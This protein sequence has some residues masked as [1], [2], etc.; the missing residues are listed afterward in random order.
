[1]ARRILIASGKGGVGK[2]T[3]SAGLGEMLAELGASVCVVDFDFA[4]NNLD[5]AL[6]VEG[7]IVYDLYDYLSGRCKL[8]Q[9]LTQVSEKGNFYF[10]STNKVSFD[11]YDED[12]IKETIMKLSA[13]FDYLIF[14]CSAGLSPAFKLGVQLASEAFIVVCP[15][16]FSLK[17][18]SIVKNY[19]ISQNQKDIGLIINRIRGDLVACGQM[20]NEKQ[21]EDILQTHVVGVIPESDG[22]ITNGNLT[23]VCESSEA[24]R[25]ALKSFA[26]NVMYGKT[27]VFDYLSKYRGLIGKIRAKIKKG[28]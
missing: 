24:M 25:C 17:D 26:Q 23:T 18:A 28:A 9:A 7:K 3:I 10:L 16:I 12:Q 5:L 1:M 6:G 27:L 22:C 11:C 20:L 14:D 21:I 15:S 4:L 2:T 13:I 19:L 8:R